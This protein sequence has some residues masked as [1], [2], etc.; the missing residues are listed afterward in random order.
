MCL[1]RTYV[2]YETISLRMECA[3]VLDLNCEDTVKS[4]FHFCFDCAYLKTMTCLI[5]TFVEKLQNICYLT[6]G[7][8]VR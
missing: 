5:Q 2:D 3:Q 4:I 6:A 7:Q 8:V 1:T